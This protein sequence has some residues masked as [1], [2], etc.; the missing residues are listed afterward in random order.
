M[1]ESP[2][3]EE[4]A[5]YRSL[6]DQNPASLVFAALVEALRKRGAHEEALEVGRRGVDRHPEYVGGL[7]ALAKVH[8]DLGKSTEALAFVD[9]ILRQSPENL[10]ALRL[11]GTIEQGRGNLAQ[12]TKLYKRI[13]EL[14]PKDT[15]TQDLLR[16]LEER[17]A[18][19][20]APN[21]RDDDAEDIQLATMTLVELFAA[22]GYRKRARE[23]CERILK[24]EPTREDVMRKLIELGERPPLPPGFG[25]RSGAE[26]N[27]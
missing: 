3:D 18:A 21:S 16:S 22:Q 11:R 15:A 7:L 27:E 6:L 1:A 4:V 13:L 5:R 17:T 9:R 20:R 25:R 23:A 8:Y 14:Y 26:A 19:L 12:A 24:A 2:Q 10:A